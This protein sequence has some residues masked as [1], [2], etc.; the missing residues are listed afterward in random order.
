MADREPKLPADGSPVPP[1]YTQV[2]ILFP[3]THVELPPAELF[4]QFPPDAQKAILEAF[5][6]EQIQRHHW[7]RTH[8]QND[9]DLNKGAQEKFFRWRMAGL[10]CATLLAVVVY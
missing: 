2:N 7:L 4:N 8:Q 3:A 9:H 5:K 6:T 1:T 10:Y